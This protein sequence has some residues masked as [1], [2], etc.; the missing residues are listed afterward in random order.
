M[1]SDLD[2]AAEEG[3]VGESAVVSAGCRLLGVLFLVEENEELE[4]FVEFDGEV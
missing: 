2:A 1:F 4:V 3:A